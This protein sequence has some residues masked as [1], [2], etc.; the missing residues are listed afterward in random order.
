M[1]IAEKARQMGI[2]P[3]A[4]QKRLSRRLGHRIRLND[5]FTPTYAEALKDAVI[6]PAASKNSLDLA[7]NENRLRRQAEMSFI[8][9]QSEGNSYKEKKSR[10]SSANKAI[11]VG[12]DLCLMAI[13]SMHS[14]LIYQEATELAGVVGSLFGVIV[15]LTTAS[16]FLMSA[17]PR[18][19]G[20]SGDALL[21]ILGLDVLSTFLHFEA[22]RQ[23]VQDYLAV[24]F[25]CVVA[26]LSFLAMYLY[27]QKNSTIKLFEEDV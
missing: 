12:A 11:S 27:R 1:T 8:P 5:D 7:E 25:A 20:V 21:V 15:L 14:V 13:P 16:A 10:F 2:S 22:F 19:H 9:K 6:P 18:W 24:G 26:T 3:E 17:S 23:H 4:L